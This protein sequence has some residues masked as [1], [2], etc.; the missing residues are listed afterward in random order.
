MPRILTRYWF[1]AAVLVVLGFAALSVDLPLARWALRKECPEVLSQPAYLAETF[2]DGI[3]VLMILAAIYVIDRRRPETL[4]RVVA[5]ALGAGLAANIFK[6]LISRTRPDRFLFDGGV[7]A[8]FRDWLPGASAGTLGQSFP[9]AH[10]ATATGFAIGLAWLYPRGR[11]VFAAFALFAGAQRIIAN[12]HYLSDVCWG[13]ALGCFV[14]LACVQPT[15]VS[16]WFDRLEAWLGPRLA[17]YRQPGS[18]T[19]AFSPS[20]IAERST[21]KPTDAR[22]A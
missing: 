14:G 8:T 6:L 12:K 5:C 20:T 15:P 7:W 18:E 4:S 16:R 9:S 17:G 21:I 22:A 13:A 19:A 11:W 3:G 10:M 1:V 2:A